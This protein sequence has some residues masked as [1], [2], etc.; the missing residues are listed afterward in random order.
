MPS[1]LE[2]HEKKQ[3][4]ARIAF[5]FFILI[6]LIV[7]LF[8]FGLPLLING[9]VYISNLFK[10]KELPTNNN[11]QIFGNIQ[12]TDIPDATNSAK[13]I[14]SGTLDQVSSVEFY[15]NGEKVKEVDT[16][17][18][19]N[20]TTELGDLKP[21]DNEVYAIGLFKGSTQKKQTSKYSV[22]YGNKK[23][24]LDISEP[25]DNST[26]THSEIKIAGKT[27]P[28]ITVQINS[29]PVVVGSSGDFQ[30]SIK[31]NEGDNK[32]KIDVSDSAGNQDEKTITVK[33]EKP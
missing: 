21:G 20:F 2:S 33:Y 27:D 17:D 10:H 18:Q 22:V 11:V 31:L 12:I 28:G 7:L 24:K 25:S 32:I 14:V 4:A 5:F 30:T 3:I 6:V 13:F 26:T 8:T 16:A 15:I 19:N 1:R 23:P 29:L 9:S